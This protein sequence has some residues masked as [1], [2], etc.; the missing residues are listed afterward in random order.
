MLRQFVEALSPSNFVLTNPEV[1]QATIES[2]GENLVRGLGNLLDD[3][4]R[5]DGRL[6][7][8]TVDADAFTLG[9]NIGDLGGLSI[10]YEAYHLALGDRPAPV[11]DRLTG[12][13]RLFIG[14]AQVW[15]RKF[16]DEALIERIKSDPHS[17]SE[18]RANG[19]LENVPAF[20][21]AFNTRAGDGMWKDPEDRVQIW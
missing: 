11:I 2:G 8:K 17:P 5:S 7:V 12:D 14:W 9:E 15:A 19:T 4:E 16:R 21:K 20:H 3:L 18:Y 10:A 13:Q 6:R 1:L